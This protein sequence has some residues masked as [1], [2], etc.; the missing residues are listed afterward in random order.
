MARLQKYLGERF[1]L[2]DVPVIC[3]CPK[4][5]LL[6]A[7]LLIVGVILGI[8]PITDYIQLHI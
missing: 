2:G 1:Q 8:D 3:I 5:G 4:E 6:E 7:F